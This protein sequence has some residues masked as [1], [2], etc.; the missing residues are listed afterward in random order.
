MWHGALPA[1]AP[2]TR[3]GYR[4]DGP[5][6]PV[7]GRRF[8]PDKLLL[9]PPR[10][11]AMEIVKALPE[12]WPRRIVYVSC[13]PATLARDLNALCAGGVFH[14]VKVTPLDILS[15]SRRLA[16]APSTACSSRT[17][18]DDGSVHAIAAELIDRFGP[19]PGEVAAERARPGHQP[20]QPGR[21]VTVDK[22]ALRATRS[23][24]NDVRRERRR[25]RT[26]QNSI[27]VRPQG[28]ERR[29]AGLVFRAIVEHALKRRLHDESEARNAGALAQQRL[30]DGHAHGI[31]CR[32]HHPVSP[33]FLQGRLLHPVVDTGSSPDVPAGRCAALR[34]IYPLVSREAYR[35]NVVPNKGG[36][37]Q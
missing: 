22:G 24:L 3:Y 25:L 1:V 13:D 5:W 28:R 18:A 4:A 7:H 26:L 36:G 29:G 33:F 34:P 21:A 6:D 10:E 14:L 35:S 31:Y 9:D 27:K 20:G 23:G 37:S 32:R 11:G 19:L 2:G 15:R 8:N 12:A 17:P 16:S 30:D